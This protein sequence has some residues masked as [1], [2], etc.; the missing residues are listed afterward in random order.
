MTVAVA[1][2]DTNKVKL[3]L[4]FPLRNICVE[5]V[6]NVGNKYSFTNKSG[7]YRKLPIGEEAILIALSSKNG[8]PYYGS[9]KIK[10]VETGAFDLT[11]SET[12][13]EEIKA[14]LALALKAKKPQI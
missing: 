7:A 13:M 1:G 5:S 9:S 11:V 6:N 10:I 2:V 4:V 12:T 3:M 14:S 8:K